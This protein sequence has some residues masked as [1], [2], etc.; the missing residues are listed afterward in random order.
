MSFF[1]IKV[2]S[3]IVTQNAT[4]RICWNSKLKANRQFR[5]LD[6]CSKIQKLSILSGYQNTQSKLPETI[7]TIRQVFTC[8]VQV[9]FFLSFKVSE[10]YLFGG[11]K[12]ISELLRQHVSDEKVLLTI[13]SISS[14]ISPESLKNYF[15]KF[16]SI[17]F[18]AFLIG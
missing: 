17:L 12:S 4:H 8:A 11:E 9:Q 6:N 16:L 15:S 18:N 10:S 7:Y 5:K 2:G 13:L 3:I 1:V 14:D